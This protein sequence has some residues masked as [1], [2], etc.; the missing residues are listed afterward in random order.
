MFG[1]ELPP[2]RAAVLRGSTY[3]SR[4]FDY[5]RAIHTSRHDAPVAAVG[6]GAQSPVLDP[7]FLDDVP[8]ARRFVAV[9]AER[10]RASRCAA[11]SPPRCWS[12]WC[13][14]RPDHRVPVDV[15]H[16][17]PAAVR[18][19]AAWATRVGGLACRCTPGCTGAGSAATSERHCAS[20][21][22]RSGTPST[23]GEVSLF[24]QGVCRST[25]SV[26]RSG[27]WP[28]GWRPRGDPVAVPGDHRVSR[29]PR[30]PPGERQERRGL[31]A[32]AAGLDAMI[33]F[34]FHGNMVALTQGVPCFYF[35]YDS[36]ITEFCR[37]YRLPHLA[38]ED[39]G[40]PRSPDPGARLGRT[41]ERSTVASASSGRSTRRTASAPRPRR[42]TRG[43]VGCVQTSGGHDPRLPDESDPCPS[44]CRRPTA[45]RGPPRRMGKTGSSSLQARFHRSRARL[46]SAACSTRSPRQAPP[47]PA[48]PGDAART[49]T[50]PGPRSTGGARSSRRRQSCGRPSSRPVPRSWANSGVHGPAL[51]RGA[52]RRRPTAP[53]PARA[54]RPASPARSGWWPTC[55][56]RTTTSPA[57][58]SRW[59]SG[60]RSAGWPSGSGDGPRRASTTTTPGSW[61]GAT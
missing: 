22:G 33:G 45:R 52:L 38:V 4:Q 10:S 39:G 24:E 53:E 36:R 58:T 42:V 15:L 34:R 35:V 51:G 54:A 61:P 57:A 41:S 1:Q 19:P 60:G 3:L 21:T 48:G 55:G 2:V 46:R 59:S 7:G 8:D 27:R 16:A 11:S 20:T 29:G 56:A 31:A 14:E 28:S 17:P 40:W 30:R 49:S 6:L 12:G 9:L 5:E 47:H 32:R 25:S 13:A 18:V 44:R 50:A 23:R 43:S 37:L 26:T